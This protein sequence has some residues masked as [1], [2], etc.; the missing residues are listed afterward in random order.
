M[1]NA[2]S[3][4]LNVF[5][6]GFRPF[7]FLR[8]ALRSAQQDDTEILRKSVVGQGGLLQEGLSK[9]SILEGVLLYVR[10]GAYSL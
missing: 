10:L 1:R 4:P 6:F 7:A 2:S 8:S 9:I 3:A 5:G